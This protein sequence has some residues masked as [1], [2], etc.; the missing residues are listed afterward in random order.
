MVRSHTFEGLGMLIEGENE[1]RPLD[2]SDYKLLLNEV[3]DVV[4][5]DE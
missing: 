2:V 3:W 5:G 4:K 1:W